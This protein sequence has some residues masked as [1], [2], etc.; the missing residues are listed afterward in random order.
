ML[1]PPN[2]GAV[3]VTVK[4]PVS[5]SDLVQF[6]ESISVGSSNQTH[7]FIFPA[8]HTVSGVITDHLGNPI[9]GA[10]AFLSSDPGSVY[11]PSSSSPFI[12]NAQGMYSIQVPP[13]SYKLSVQYFKSQVS[14]PNAPDNATLL[15]MNSFPVSSNTTKDMQFSMVS[16]SGK[17]L[18]G[19]SVPV[20]GVKLEATVQYIDGDGIRRQS[21][22]QNSSVVSDANGDYTMLVPPNSGVV[23]V[24]VK[25]PVESGF[26]STPISLMV[27]GNQQS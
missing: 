18:D 1:V 19:N 15:T 25:P 12:T 6:L 2:S 20:S 5:R 13:G 8:S 10:R 3:D 24:T 21:F 16:I 27:T 23:D 11:Y 4:P 14:V 7:D 9:Q 22:N 17:T 26:S